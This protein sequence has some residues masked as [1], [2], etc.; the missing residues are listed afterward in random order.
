MIADLA[1][2]VTTR[3]CPVRVPDIVTLR[4]DQPGSV[5]PLSFRIRE[6]QA[7]SEHRAYADRAAVEVG[8]R[9]VE[10]LFGVAVGQADMRGVVAGGELSRRLAEGIPRPRKLSPRPPAS[11]IVAIQTLV[12]H[13]I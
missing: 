2:E 5:Q 8:R 12:R 3:T 4:Q 13:D 7:A 11:S 10:Q 6:C 9:R 1:A